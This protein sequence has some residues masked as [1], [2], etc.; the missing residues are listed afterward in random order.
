[1][2]RNKQQKRPGLRSTIEDPAPRTGIYEGDPS[3]GRCDLD[4]NV[5]AHK[6]FPATRNSNGKPA[7]KLAFSLPFVQKRDPEVWK[8]HG[9]PPH[10]QRMID[11]DVQV[12]RLMS[13][14][15]R[16]AQCIS[17]IH[18]PAMKLKR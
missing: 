8:H 4:G 11:L 5:V 17:Y 7:H 6:D 12:I 14:K 10:F 15:S 9:K 13:E 2:H 3:Y 16:L 1:M 18:T